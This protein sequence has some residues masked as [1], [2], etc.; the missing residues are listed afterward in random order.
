MRRTALNPWPWSIPYGFN[1]G[2]LIE[3]DFRML[4][5]AGQTSV[6]SEG[7]LLYPEDPRAQLEKALENVEIVLREGGMDLSNLVRL[8]IY[9]TD[10]EGLLPHMD[11]ISSRLGAAGVKPAQTLL[12]VSR[13]AFPGVKV[14]LEA[15]AVG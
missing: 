13:L 3:G 7:I 10:M 15:T 5:C 8:V 4:L 12:G 14:E 9:A 2:E 11:V 1:Q 6:D